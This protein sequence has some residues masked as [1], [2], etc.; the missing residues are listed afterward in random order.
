MKD[1]SIEQLKNEQ[2]EKNELAEK[3]IEMS[4]QSLKE[5]REKLVTL[6]N[7]IVKMQEKMAEK[8]KMIAQLKKNSI[9]NQSQLVNVE[10]SEGKRH[11]D[12]HLGKLLFR[13]VL[14]CFQN[15]VPSEQINFDF[16]SNRV[17]FKGK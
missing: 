6:E 11:S 13:F 14:C 16:D 17:E 3:Q 2:L 12:T 1:E 5:L 9:K 8:D 15:L 7:E 10:K 4:R